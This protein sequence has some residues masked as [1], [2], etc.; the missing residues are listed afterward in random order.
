M[1]NINWLAML[2]TFLKSFLSGFLA[3]AGASGVSGEVSLDLL[4]KAAI[5]GL[6]GAFYTIMEFA[7]PTSYIRPVETPTLT[8]LAGGKK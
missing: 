5:A 8:K 3:V 4:G 7:T 1:E 2:A 6:F